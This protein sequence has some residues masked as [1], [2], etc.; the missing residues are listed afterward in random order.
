MAFSPETLSV[1]VQPIGGVGMRFV[2]YRSDDAI[3]TVSGSGYFA[4]GESY[5][6]R[7]HDLV[8]VSPVSGSVEPY[9]LVVTAV[10]SDGSVTATQ[11]IFDEDLTA[12][13]G[14]DT[15]DGNFIVGNGT[16]WVAEGGATARAS[17]GLTIGTHV[18]AYSSNL[19]LWSAESPTGYLTTAS[20]ASTY[21]TQAAAA[22]AYQPVNVVLLAIA[23]LAATS[24][25]LDLL[26]LA[27][28]SAGRTALQLGAAATRAVAT[29]GEYSSASN[30]KAL[31]AE[32]VWGDLVVL[33]D[34]ANI[35]V[36]MNSGYDFGGASNAALAL[37]GDR[38]LSAPTNVRNGKKG[39]L[40]FTASGSTRTLTLDAAWVRATGVEA[41]PYS[42]TTSQTLGVAYVCRGTNVVVTG[43]VRVG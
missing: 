16:T 6:L 10:D 22:L 24:Y 35:A 8:F 40:W 17:L 31:G 13:V 42:I 14:L 30:T 4:G 27:D 18:Q 19:A 38:A 3:G 23:E 33:T 9:I 41:G 15:A 36:D 26:E 11:T 28:A 32:S 1:M 20:A 43:I 5:G 37:G 12:L 39:V 21:L 2:S 29:L 25:G 34:G 7:L